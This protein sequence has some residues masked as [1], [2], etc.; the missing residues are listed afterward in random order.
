MSD[1]NLNQTKHIKESVEYK[2]YFFVL[3]KLLSKQSM[4]NYHNQVE[5]NLLLSFC[6][7]SRIMMKELITQLLFRSDYL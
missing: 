5:M 2:R 7:I 3:V 1:L 4:S 6:F